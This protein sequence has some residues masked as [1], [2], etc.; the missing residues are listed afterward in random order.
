MQVTIF[1]CTCERKSQRIVLVINENG[2]KKSFVF[3][4]LLIKKLSKNSDIGNNVTEAFL[5]FFKIIRFILSETVTHL[6]MCLIFQKGIFI[7]R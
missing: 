2:F 6:K 3:R 1:L 4:M 7:I 5:Y